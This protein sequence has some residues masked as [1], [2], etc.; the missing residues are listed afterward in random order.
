MRV[1]V[2]TAS[3]G[4]ALAH[5]EAW[6]PRASRY[7]AERNY[8]RPGHENVSRLSP[9]LRTRLL[10][11]REAVNAAL[12]RYKMSTIEKFVQE[13]L[14]RTYWKGWLQ[15]RPRVWDDY[16]ETVRREF[17]ALAGEEA[18][19]YERAI[20]GQTG[21]ECFDHWA[22]E[23][24]ETGYLHNHARMWF[25]SIWVFTLELP[26]ALGADYFFRH[27]LDGD[28]ASNTL[29]WRWVAGLQTKGKN[30]A[31]RASNIAKYTEGR[32]NPY[33]QLRERPSPLYKT[34]EYERQPLMPG[35]ALPSGRLGL[36]LH[37]DDC[38]P[39]SGPLEHARFV[40][41]AGGWHGSLAEEVGWAQQVQTFHGEAI[42]DARQR[43]AAHFS[44]DAVT[45]E[46]AAWQSGAVAWARRHTLDAVVCLEAPVGPWRDALAGL[47]AAL[48][49]HGLALAQVRRPWD[50]TLWP[51]ATAGFFN[52]WK[53][54]EPRLPL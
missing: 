54:T 39:E 5:L 10:H 28:A 53:K 20:K 29:S 33:G 31:A 44:V 9:Y 34:A 43:A 17:D 48:E 24:N 25:A 11:E 14:W 40:S 30:Y 46:P 45:I 19:T 15:M 51:L 26:W 32:F 1:V 4:A 49:P 8:D 12:S 18:A 3:R 23:L 41:I 50:D 37:G 38:L 52:F 13:V 6:I 36:L 47:R 22:H 2:S 7:A 27:L 16:R 21:I 35:Q 42:A